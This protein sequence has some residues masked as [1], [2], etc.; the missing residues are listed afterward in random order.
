MT[1]PQT[2]VGVGASE[3]FSNAFALRGHNGHLVC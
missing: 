3:R 1:L 2:T